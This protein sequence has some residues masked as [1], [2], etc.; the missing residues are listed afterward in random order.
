MYV[1]LAAKKSRA[2]DGSN[3]TKFEVC[4]LCSLLTH[5]Q[6]KSK[7]TRKREKYTQKKK[8]LKKTRMMMMKK[9]LK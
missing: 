8:L 7:R 4:V 6:T 5:G 3:R 2:V 1:S 9:N